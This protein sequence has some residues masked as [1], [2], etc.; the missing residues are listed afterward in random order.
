[1]KI[2]STPLIPIARQ[3]VSQTT[4]R[5][6]PVDIEQARPPS[7]VRDEVQVYKANHHPLREN[8]AQRG[9]GSEQSKAL[10]VYKMTAAIDAGKGDGDLI[11]VDVFA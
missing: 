9:F 1:M 7:S 3:D 10:D 11:G 5:A 6:L 8:P 2:S 4:R